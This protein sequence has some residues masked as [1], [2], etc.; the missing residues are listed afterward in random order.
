MHYLLSPLIVW[1]ADA[2]F[3]R[4]RTWLSE[5][6]YLCL[7]V[8]YLPNV[9]CSVLQ[10]PHRPWVFSCIPSPC[11]NML[12]HWRGLQTKRSGV[13]FQNH[14]GSYDGVWIL[15]FGFH[16]P[17]RA[18][19][20]CCDDAMEAYFWCAPLSEVLCLP[21]CACSPCLLKPG[22]PHLSF[23]LRCGQEDV[24]GWSWNDDVCHFFAPMH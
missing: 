13:F 18:L 9:A 15:F 10:L 5:K 8:C 23:Q 11:N 12:L 4:G 14:A 22:L 2:L 1:W 21:R 7:L 24:V 19:D 16:C 6:D 17:L 20:L 3:V